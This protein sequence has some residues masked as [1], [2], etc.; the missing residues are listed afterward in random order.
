MPETNP[1]AQQSE[2]FP[3]PFISLLHNFRLPFSFPAPAPAQSDAQKPADSGGEA[4]AYTKTDA[5]RF[6]DPRPAVPP[7]LKIE[8]EEAAQSAVVVWQIY[9]LGGY[10]LARW[11]WAKWKQ[12]DNKD[13]PSDD[14]PSPPNN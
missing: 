4:A 10:L 7:P 3:N 6:S 2:K 8:T 12:K 13:Q 14:N 9:A 5:V 1:A 11:I